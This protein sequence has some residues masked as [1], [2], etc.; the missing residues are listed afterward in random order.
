MAQAVKKY[1]SH[2]AKGIERAVLLVFGV[3]STQR[4]GLSIVSGSFA[5][6]R[7]AVIEISGGMNLRRLLGGARLCEPLRVKGGGRLWNLSGVPS[8][9]ALMRVADPRS[10]GRASFRI[11]Y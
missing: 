11:S 5:C 3:V 9:I 8:V 4:Q 1:C 6:S 7:G 10:G 2:S